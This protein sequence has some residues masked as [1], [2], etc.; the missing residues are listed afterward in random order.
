MKKLSEVAINSIMSCLIWP[1][2]GSCVDT[3][4]GLSGSSCTF[5]SAKIFIMLLSW[6]KMELRMLLS[7]DNH[8]C[9]LY[10]LLL[11][12]FEGF[13]LITNLS[14]KLFSFYIGSLD[15]ILGFLNDCSAF[16]LFLLPAFACLSHHLDESIYVASSLALFHQGELIFGHSLQECFGTLNLLLVVLNLFFLV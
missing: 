10:A 2:S 3:F 1:R 11:E 15:L 6:W 4:E 7:W 8:I 9:Y 5:L 14:F 13:L 16:V 12:L